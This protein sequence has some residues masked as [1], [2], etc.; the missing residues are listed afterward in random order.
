MEPVS[1]IVTALVAGATAGMT[2]A[3]KD[4]VRNAVLS[5]YRELRERVRARLAANEHGL[6]V[7]DRFE[8]D[9]QTW[10]RP[11]RA[12][13]TDAGAAEDAELMSVAQQ[14]L[15]QTGQEDGSAPKYSTRFQGEVGSAVVGDDA[16]VN[17]TINK[18]DKPLPT[19]DPG[20]G[21][22]TPSM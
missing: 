4:S 3:A 20:P 17:V 12:E 6:L 1:L 13:L 8:R 10:A 9:P 21:T 15:Q 18:P 16:H 22:A 14:V 7:F 11:L 2:D 19:S 5:A